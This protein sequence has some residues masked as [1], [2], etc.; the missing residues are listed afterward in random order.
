MFAV[1]GHL[2]S[3]LS[4]ATL[5][6][7]MKTELWEPNNMLRTFL[8]L[9]DARASGNIIAK[10]YFYDND[11]ASYVEV[12]YVEFPGDEGA[13]M[14]ISNALDYAKYLRLMIE[15]GAPLSSSA[16]QAI[17]GP[18]MLTSTLLAQGFDVG[19][20]YYGLGWDGAVSL[21]EASFRHG[22]LIGE[23]TSI[24]WIFPRRKFGVVVFQNSANDV[25]NL[26]SRRII[27]DFFRTPGAERTDFEGR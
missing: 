20:Q 27:Y 14:V 22:G 25:A 4:G 3:V 7:F 10:P 9:Q 17:L 11:T 24:M 23:F 8:S 5:S 1:I 12:P 15:G 6:E 2:I 21:G 19:A 13:G 26:I 16:R 18:H